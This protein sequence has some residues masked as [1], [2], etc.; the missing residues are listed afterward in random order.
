MKSVNGVV[1]DAVCGAFT[2]GGLAV[3]QDADCTA[4]GMSEMT[5][6]AAG[7]SEDRD[8]NVIPDV[9]ERAKFVFKAEAH[10]FCRG[11]R[12]SCQSTKRL[13]RSRSCGLQSDHPGTLLVR[14][15]N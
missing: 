12:S 6:V 8:G 11:S 7:L 15:T 10:R 2:I 14:A 13:T 9:L 4:N 3:A 5:E 1:A